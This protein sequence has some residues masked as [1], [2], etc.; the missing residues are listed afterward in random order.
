MGRRGPPPKP[1]AFRVLAGNPSKRPMNTREP[2]PRPLEPR[3]PK[4]LD[5]EAK[6]AWKWLVA[7]LRYMR[8]LTSADR[9]AMESYCHAYSRWRAT[10]AFLKVHGD[11][12]PIRDD[13][14]RVR[15]MQQFPQVAIS[16]NLQQ[17]L[18]AYQQELGLT[19]ASR[20]RIQV[21]WRHDEERER[22]LVFDR[23]GRPI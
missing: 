19:P 13:A 14:G 18:K 5:P 21:P 6:R 12:Y 11:V 1:T 8:L 3:C 7:E 16:R 9:H 15:Y 4:W 23:L 22:K 17:L 10:E 2:Q 20:T